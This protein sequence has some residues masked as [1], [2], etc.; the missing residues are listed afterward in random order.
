[1]SGR[2][3]TRARLE[4]WTAEALSATRRALLRDG[5][6][7]LAE[8]RHENAW[9]A[10]KVAASFALDLLGRDL[11]PG[12][13]GRKPIVLRPLSNVI[14]SRCTDCAH[15]ETHT[16][17]RQITEAGTGAHDARFTCAHCAGGMVQM[18]HT[19]QPFT[20]ADRAEY[21]SWLERR[22]AVRRRAA[23]AE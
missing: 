13:K 7:P 10:A 15:T 5:D 11:P 1:M 14:A 3:H 19:V 16:R 9:R 12:F 4:A 17:L 21:E 22:P 18:G 6:G 20:T 2:A 23:E 8:L